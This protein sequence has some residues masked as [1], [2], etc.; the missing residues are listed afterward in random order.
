MRIYL[1]RHGDAIARET[2]GVDSD[3][4]RWLTDLGREEAG[5]TAN[6]LKQLG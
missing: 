2:P 4:E 5:W 6:I 3:A 1:V